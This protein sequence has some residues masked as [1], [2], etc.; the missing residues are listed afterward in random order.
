MLQNGMMAQE[1][2]S[3]SETLQ[4]PRLSDKN[5]FPSTQNLFEKIDKRENIYY[6]TY[7]DTNRRWT[8]I[9]LLLC[10][11]KASVYQLIWSQVI[12]FLISYYLLFFMYRFVL[13]HYPTQKQTFE[14]VCIYAERFTQAIP[15]TFL[16]GFYVSQV[17]NRWWNQFMTLPYPDILALKLVA[18]I[19]GRVS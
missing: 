19:P 9:L 6:N 8:G 15:I 16:I 4:P 14:I 10:R 17:V 18:F 11:W 1:K 3:E 13:W 2:S 12:V 5:K 7:N